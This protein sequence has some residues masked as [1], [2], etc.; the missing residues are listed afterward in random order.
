MVLTCKQ[1]PSH[2]DVIR[3]GAR[4]CSFSRRVTVHLLNFH[5]YQLLSELTKLWFYLMLYNYRYLFGYQGTDTW[6]VRQY[7]Q[8]TNEWWCLNA[9]WQCPSYRDRMLSWSVTIGRTTPELLAL[10]YLSKYK[11]QIVWNQPPLPPHTLTL[12]AHHAYLYPHS[13]RH[14]HSRWD[15]LSYKQDNWL[16]LTTPNVCLIIPGKFYATKMR[17]SWISDVWECKVLLVHI[18]PEAVNVLFTN[19]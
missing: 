13:E 12:C 17:Q 14:H 18:H 16:V 1:P 19:I 2:P 7:V 6:T 15:L 10:Y 8:S 11:A 4:G 5:H 9:H 3:F